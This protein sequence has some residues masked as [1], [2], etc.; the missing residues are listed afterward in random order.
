MVNVQFRVKHEYTQ[1]TR[2]TIMSTGCIV[3]IYMHIERHYSRCT[4]SLAN[5]LSLLI[6]IISKHII[7]FQFYINIRIIIVKPCMHYPCDMPLSYQISAPPANSS[8]VTMECAPSRSSSAKKMRP[9]RSSTFRFS[10][11][12]R[13]AA[14]PKVPAVI[15]CAA[16]SCTRKMKVQ[17]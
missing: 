13:R 7:Q 14:L 1:C 8:L 3:Y 6:Y 9:W 16:V 17:V 2:I 15:E 10:E 4:H 5:T 12:F 11:S